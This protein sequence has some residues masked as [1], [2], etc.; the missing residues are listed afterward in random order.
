MGNAP[1]RL[2]ARGRSVRGDELGHAGLGHRREIL[3]LVSE[4]TGLRHAGEA[5][6][7]DPSEMRWQRRRGPVGPAVPLLQEPHTERRARPVEEA[8]R[9]LAAAQLAIAEEQD[10]IA[11]RPR[12]REVV[13]D[14]H[15]A[16]ARCV[17]TQGHH[18]LCTV[19]LGHS[20]VG[21]V[22]QDGVRV[23]LE[24]LAPVPHI[25]TQQRA[26]RA[27]VQPAH[28][29]GWF[30]VMAQ[31][32]V[33]PRPVTADAPR[34]LGSASAQRAEQLA[35]AAARRAEQHGD[36]MVAQRV[37]GGAQHAAQPAS[38][39]HVPALDFSVCFALHSDVQ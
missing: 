19:Q 1:I 20:A 4:E 12:E 18:E 27:L 28:P 37:A 8:Q 9:A 30:L 34:L 21:L 13:R 31:R 29:R 26:A 22:Q 23:A 24:R 15:G 35:L 25:V 11:N 33:T 2:P 7:D 6:G 36:G 39:K 38:V 10:V 5:S 14:H 17:L 3:R 16:A 32:L